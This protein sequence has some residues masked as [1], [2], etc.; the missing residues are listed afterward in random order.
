MKKVIKASVKPIKVDEGLSLIETDIDRLF[1]IL[2]HL[3]Q[4]IE[5]NQVYQ[6]EQSTV[7]N[8]MLRTAR[9]SAAAAIK[10]LNGAVTLI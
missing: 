1:E 7:L 2:Q 8:K 9:N 10:H 3:D 6:N 5:Y 4:L